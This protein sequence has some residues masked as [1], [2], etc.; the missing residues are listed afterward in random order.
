MKLIKSLR[1]KIHLAVAALTICALVFSSTP[2]TA[3]PFSG[4]RMDGGIGNIY[5]YIDGSGSPQATY[6]QNL[7]KT[8]VNNWMY[9]GV[10]AN[11]FYR[12]GYV[13][14]GASGSKMDWYARSSSFWGNDGGNVL[15]ETRFYTYSLSKVYPWNSGWYSAEFSLN[16]PLLRQ[17]RY[18]NDDAIWVFIHE[19]GHGFGMAH[20]D[21]RNSVMYP[22]LDGCNVRRVQKVDNDLLNSMY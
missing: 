12:Q 1:N 18:S 3:A 19:M 16:N 21:D 9:T 8:A 6:W 4:Y 15:G 17:D 20:V 13:N 10:G 2:V 5:M 22:Y 7:I 14:S 11:D